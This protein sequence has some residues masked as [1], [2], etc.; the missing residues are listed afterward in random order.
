MDAEPIVCPIK[1]ISLPLTA[2]LSTIANIRSILNLLVDD[3]FNCENDAA[4]T[5]FLSAIQFK[6][7]VDLA[8]FEVTNDEPQSVKIFS[9][10]VSSVF[11][12]SVDCS[13]MLWNLKRTRSDTL[14]LLHGLADGYKWIN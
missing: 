11:V 9:V 1:S 10:V 13:L 4:D 5:N 6:S 12:D 14:S 8:I 3:F 2:P 7:V